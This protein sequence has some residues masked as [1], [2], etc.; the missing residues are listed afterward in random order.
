MRLLIAFIA[1]YILTRLGCGKKN[2]LKSM[3]T[4]SISTRLRMAVCVG[5]LKSNRNLY[6]YIRQK[7]FARVV[8]ILYGYC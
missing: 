3:C 2:T 8:V 7:K 4:K 5:L 6:I 1:L